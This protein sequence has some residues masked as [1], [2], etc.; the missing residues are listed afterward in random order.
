MPKFQKIKESFI[1]KPWIYLGVIGIVLGVVLGSQFSQK[2]PRI[3][4]PAVSY[5]ALDE[6]QTNLESEQANLKKSLSS[7]DGKIDELNNQIEIKQS[8]K[9]D[10][11]NEVETLKRK[12][13]LTDVSAPGISV[14]LDDSDDRK[15][16]PNSI[17][18]AS[19]MRDL[20]NNLWINGATAI[21]I[22]GAGHIEERVG[23]TT[24]ID[25]IVNTVLING[26]KIVPPFKIKAIGNREK[27][28]SSINDQKALKLIY[29][30]VSKEG[31]VFHI[32]DGETMI[33]VPKFTGSLTFKNAKI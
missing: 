32:V 1:N 15:N 26:T 13:G 3:I 5:I 20:V 27:L 18:H 28:I 2:I 24:S 11:I 12:A 25:C 14:L 22:E 21:S 8:G 19:D 4:S 23:P 17:A 6:M 10:L 9:K 7:T 31:L 16:N 33:T 30:R 29:D